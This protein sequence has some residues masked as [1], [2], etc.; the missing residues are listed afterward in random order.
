LEIPERLK[1]LLESKKKLRDF[2]DEEFREHQEEMT[3]LTL[4][5]LSDLKESLKK[6][7]DWTEED[8]HNSISETGDG[9][10]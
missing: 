10:G 5:H 1:E 6:E 7:W 9:D 2:T 8:W 3:D 4:K